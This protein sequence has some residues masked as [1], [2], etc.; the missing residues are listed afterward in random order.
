MAQVL[1]TPRRASRHGV[2][3]LDLRGKTY[4]SHG[5]GSLPPTPHTSLT[6]DGGDTEGLSLCVLPVCDDNSFRRAVLTQ[7]Y[8]TRH[9]SQQQPI[10]NS[11]RLW[12]AFVV[13]LASC[14]SALPRAS[15][16]HRALRARLTRAE[17][18][19]LGRVPCTQARDGVARRAVLSLIRDFGP[20][21]R[22]PCA[23][24]RV[25]VEL[26]GDAVQG[27]KT[28]ASVADTLAKHREAVSAATDY[29]HPSARNGLE[30]VL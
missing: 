20:A 17:N 14:G 25:C 27:H 7:A 28:E 2:C 18:T 10:G 15:Y 22:T 6:P 12:Y 5:P 3:R 30:S 4:V 13:R 11:V 1:A 9:S 23:T 8:P 21:F 24:W 26:F 29:V 19:S 16:L